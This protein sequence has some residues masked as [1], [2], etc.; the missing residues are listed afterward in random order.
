MPEL[1]EVEFARSC[2]S[3]WLRGQKLVRVEA[4][5]NRVIRGS[6]PRAF[7]DLKGQRVTK[8]ERHGKWLLFR[9][10]SEQGILAHLGMTGKFELTM[11]GQ[12]SA[13]WSRV[14]F[15]RSGGGTP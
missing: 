2:L 11:P 15:T 9:L 8:V 10:D 1:P 13:Q 5:T 4:E 7:R 3:R 6:S 12:P 14:R